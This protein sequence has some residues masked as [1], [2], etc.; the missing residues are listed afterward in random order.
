M[1]LAYASP[2]NFQKSTC[3]SEF[4]IVHDQRKIFPLLLLSLHNII[5]SVF[6]EYSLYNFF[7]CAYY[8]LSFLID[9]FVQTPLYIAAENDEAGI[10]S[11]LLENGA[12]ANI[13][14]QLGMFDL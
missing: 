13:K 3:F 2:L 12:D 9:L 14:D 7:M 11:L 4:V 5:E 6:N 1:N 8:I 10:V